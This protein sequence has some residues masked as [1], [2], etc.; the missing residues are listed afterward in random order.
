[1]A[2][3][4]EGA[5]EAEVGG[6]VESA[7]WASVMMSGLMRRQL[8][9]VLRM[10]RRVALEGFAGVDEVEVEVADA[11]VAAAGAGVV[12]VVVVVVEVEEEEGGAV[13]CEEPAARESRRV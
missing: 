4:D 1:M 8:D 3:E 2:G 13:C 5:G 12:G 7:S 9:S 6:E 10:K 11:V